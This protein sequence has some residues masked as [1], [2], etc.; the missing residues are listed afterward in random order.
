[1]AETNNAQIPWN[2]SSLTGEGFSFV[3]SGTSTP[4]RTPGFQEEAAK[5]GSVK[6]SVVEAGT[7]YIDGTRMG[8]IS[9]NR[10]ATMTDVEVGRHDIEV[11]YNDNTEKKSITVTENRTVQ[12]AFSYRRIVETPQIDDNFISVQGGTFQMGS[13]SG[14]SDEK[15]VHSVTVSSFYISPYEVTQ[16][17]YKSVM[18]SSIQQQRDK[19]NPDWSV[20]G[21]GNNYPMYYVSWNEVVEYCNA[22]SRKEG[23]TPCYSGSG[24]SISCD[25]SADGYRLP[26]E[27]EWEYA[28]RGGN[29]SRGYTYAGGNSMGSLGWYR[30]NS[31]SKT[32]PVGGKQA[33]ELGIYDMS[34]N[35][36]EWCWDW[37]GDYSSGNQ[38]DP[39]GASSG[40]GR[41]R[42]G[43]SWGNSALFSRSALRGNNSPG[44]RGNYLGFRLV[45]SS[46]R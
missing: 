9:A 22:L 13:T 45:R 6:V 29:N 40:L 8:S 18:R 1:M 30:D 44:I 25:F 11:R 26:T 10:S 32:H 23:L 15:P 31:G 27:A 42:R 33:N 17:E 21:E 35:V 3:E 14:D 16:A 37:Y 24:N 46:V 19:A 34:G 41:V 5:Y 4:A 38:R 39:R 7:V 20:K 36:W 12:I 28:A 43:G 2:N